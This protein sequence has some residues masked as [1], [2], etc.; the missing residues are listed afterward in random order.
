MEFESSPATGSIIQQYRKLD[1]LVKRLDAAM[2]GD[3]TVQPIDN[4]VGSGESG[5]GVDGMET[6]SGSGDGE[7]GG[8]G[9]G[10]F[11]TTNSPT[12]ETSTVNKCVNSVEGCYEDIETSADGLSNKLPIVE[13]AKDPNSAAVTNLGSWNCLLLSVCVLLTYFIL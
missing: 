5:D 9:K 13:A 4:E 2:S 1:D 8:S 11:E 3:T 12:T 10:S 6:G 7:S